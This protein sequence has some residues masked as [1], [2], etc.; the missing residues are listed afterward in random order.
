MRT[1]GRSR[2]QTTIAVAFSA[3]VF[4]T[5][6]VIALLSY[7]F[8]EEAVRQ[9]SRDYTAQLIGQVQ[10]TIDTYIT[11]ME[12]IAEVVHLNDRVQRYLGQPR[13]SRESDEIE[14]AAITGF[15][16]SISRTRDD[17]SLILIVGADGRTITHDPDI[18]INQAVEIVDQEWYRRAIRSSGWTVVSPSHVQ[19]IVDGEYRWV[20]TLSRTINDPTDG[21]ILGV[22]LVD[23]NFSVINELVSRVSFGRRG[24][25]FIL[26]PEGRIVYH[27]RQELIYSNLEEEQI[28]L[29]L[30]TT[31]GS[32]AVDANLP[33]ER[34]YTVRTSTRTRWRTIGV[35]FADELVRNRTTIR[36]YYTWWSLL[37]LLIA[38]VVSIAVSHR[39]SRPLMRLRESV[40]AVEQGNFDIT[41]NVRSTNEIGEL[42]R[43]FSIMVAQIKDLM[44]RSTEEQELKRKNELRALQNQITPHFLYNTLDTVVWMAEAGQHRNVVTTISALARLLRLSISRGD[45]LIGIR[46]EIEHISSYLTIQKLRYRD[47]LDYA[48]EVDEEILDLQIP[49]VILQPLV[50][51]AIYH[52]IKNSGRR[53]HVEIRGRREAEVV[54]LAVVDDGVG[55]SPERM[56]QVLQPVNGRRHPAEEPARR[57]DRRGTRV[58]IANVHERI[59]L[60]FGP[61]YGLRFLQSKRQGTTVEVRLP[62]VVQVE[63]RAGE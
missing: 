21:E 9:T 7:T 6:L 49:K 41:V 12:Y 61:D 55:M 30:E 3:L 20:I 17:V 25:L 57:T 33:S 52:G 35:N 47:T 58:G 48:I 4:G 31:Y 39:L 10:T 40:R 11:H 23:L 1:F 34:V 18:E 44:R 43:D 27:P 59:K 51:N 29:V 53:G 45:E 8:T 54:V 56:A 46:D 50:E 42:A 19:N 37:C 2:I 28:A 5:A 13:L 14:R 63:E 16:D 32:F 24:Y 22:M 36:R 26:D 15:L 62:V 60:Y 38:V